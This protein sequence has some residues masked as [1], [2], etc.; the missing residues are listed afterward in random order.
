M[1]GGGL[2]EQ[3]RALLQGIVDSFAAHGDTNQTVVV[4]PWDDGSSGYGELQCHQSGAP[5]GESSQLGSWLAAMQ[6]SVTPV[7]QSP[8]EG[9]QSTGNPCLQA[10]VCPHLRAMCPLQTGGHLCLLLQPTTACLCRQL[11]AGALAPTPLGRGSCYSA[12]TE[13]LLLQ[14]TDG[15]LSLLQAATSTQTQ[16]HTLRML[17]SSSQLWPRSLAGSPSPPHHDQFHSDPASAY[18]LANGSSLSPVRGLCTAGAATAG[19]S[20]YCRASL[21]VRQRWCL[22]AS[23]HHG[24]CFLSAPAPISEM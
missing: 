22:V 2:A 14:H 8:V 17:S 4:L 16:S 18:A 10:G 20:C 21:G 9:V 24:L 23:R 13:R 6:H 15:Y 3:T 11:L 7:R 1:L 12:A 19:P 5:S